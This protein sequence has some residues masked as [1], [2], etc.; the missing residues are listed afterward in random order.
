MIQYIVK[1]NILYHFT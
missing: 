1:H